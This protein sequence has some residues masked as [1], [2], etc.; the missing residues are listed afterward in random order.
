MIATK[1][2]LSLLAEVLFFPKIFQ[3]RLKAR[4]LIFEVGCMDHSRDSLALQHAIMGMDLMENRIFG[5][6][7]DEEE[8]KEEKEKKETNYQEWQW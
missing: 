8:E 3:S 7:E 2:A 5:R 1:L 6:E 4:Y